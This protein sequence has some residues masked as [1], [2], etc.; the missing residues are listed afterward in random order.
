[1]KEDIGNQSQHYAGTAFDVGQTL[2]NAQRTVLRNSARNSGVWTYIEPEALSPTWVHFDRRYGTPA[3]SSGGY[4]LIRQNSR[5]N[6][7]C[8]AQDD[9]NTLGYR[10]NGLDGIFGAGTQNAVIAYQKSKGLS[11]D[12]IVGCNTWRSLQEDVVGTGA[13]STTI[14]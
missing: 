8:I 2:T 12:G 14:N 9:L 10:T 7:V 11:A 6:Y 1:M 4:P 5:G 13:T 3:C